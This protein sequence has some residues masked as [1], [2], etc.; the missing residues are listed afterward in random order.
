MVARTEILELVYVCDFL[1][2]SWSY[3]KTGVARKK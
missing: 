2:E 3:P 1:E